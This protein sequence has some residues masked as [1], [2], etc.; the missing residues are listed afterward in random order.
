MRSGVIKIFNS[1]IVLFVDR[2]SS[3]STS[4]LLDWPTVHRSLPW[5]VVLLL[6]G[7]FALAYACKVSIVIN[8]LNSSM[9]RERK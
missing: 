9:H 7:G 3:V 1:N 2:S 6:G 4:A 5:S 8:S